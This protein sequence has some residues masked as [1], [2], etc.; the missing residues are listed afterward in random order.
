MAC[1]KTRLQLEAMPAIALSLATESIPSPTAMSANSLLQ[2]KPAKR[3][4]LTTTLS[5]TEI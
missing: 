2:W 4:A 3:K 5:L 1:T